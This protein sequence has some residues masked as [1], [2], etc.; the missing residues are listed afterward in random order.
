MKKVLCFVMVLLFTVSIM[1]Y[2]L[3]VKPDVPLTCSCGG[4]NVYMGTSVG[5]WSAPLSQR[6]CVHGHGGYD[7]KCYREVTDYYE[8]SLCGR[9]LSSSYKEFDWICGSE[10]LPKSAIAA[11]VS[12]GRPELCDNCG[13]TM[14]PYKVSRGAW[15]GPIDTRQTPNGYMYLFIRDVNSFYKC[16][17]CGTYETTTYTERMWTD[18]NM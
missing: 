4:T 9:N 15:E 16:P 14:S 3:P 7:F 11:I 8:C 12:G 10:I 17:Y 13:T 6:N 18:K 2:A 1:V 5:D